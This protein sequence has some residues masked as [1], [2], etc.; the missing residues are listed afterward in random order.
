MFTERMQRKISALTYDHGGLCY[1][2]GNRLT[3]YANM[4]EFQPSIDHLIP[5]SALKESARAC[6]LPSEFVEDYD[7]ASKRNLVLACVRCNGMKKSLSIDEFNDMRRSRKRKKK[8][9]IRRS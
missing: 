3:S 8:M 6:V 4:P 2:C 9:S 5:K 7:R 1:Y